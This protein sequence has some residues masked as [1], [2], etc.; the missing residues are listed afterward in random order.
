M[1]PELSI[2]IP[3]FEE[4]SRVGGSIT[5]ILDYIRASGISAELIVV[6]DGSKDQTKATAEAAFSSAEGVPARVIRYDE[7]RG[8]GFAVRTGLAAATAPMI[9]KAIAA[10]VNPLFIAKLR[11]YR[12]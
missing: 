6:D 8:K 5:T 2:V 1:P 3:A 7:N 10:N 9:T 12:L 11:N 4:E